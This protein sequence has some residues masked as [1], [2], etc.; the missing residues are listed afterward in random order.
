MKFTSGKFFLPSV[1]CGIILL[2][3]YLWISYKLVSHYS[4]QVSCN[5]KPSINNTQIRNARKDITYT[6]NGVSIVNSSRIEYDSKQSY[7]FSEP[8]VKSGVGA[9]TPEEERR[10]CVVLTPNE[11]GL[12]NVYKQSV[13]LKESKNSKLDLLLIIFFN[14]T[15]SIGLMFLLWSYVIRNKELYRRLL[16]ERKKSEHVDEL[17]LAA[18]GLAHETKNPLGIIRGL[19]QNIADNHKNSKKTRTVAQDIMEETDVTTARL[20]DFLSYAKFRSPSPIEI[21]IRPYLERITNLINDDFINADV[22]LI[23]D[24]SNFVVIAD[25]DMLS[26]ILMNLLT[27]SLRF[28]KAGDTVTLSLKNRSNN[29]LELSVKDSGDGIPKELL[30]NI[31]KPYVT[32]SA[33]GYGI[34]LAIV[35]RIADQSGW[36]INVESV[37]DKGTTVTISN[38]KKVM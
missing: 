21:N 12:L 19:A 20:G 22:E 26:Q 33:S 31:L 8:R 24:S 5:K 29:R 30:P 13:E 18:T 38:I 4:K 16:S 9:T 32:S 6:N 10:G 15:L 7:I 25:Q 17:G 1:V 11:R 35:K 28:T 2:M 27:N 34:G 23:L 36:D 3:F 37:V 14:G